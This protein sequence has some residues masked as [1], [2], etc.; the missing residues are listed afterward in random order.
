VRIWGVCPALVEIVGPGTDLAAVLV[1]RESPGT[2]LHSLSVRG[3]AIGVGVAGASDVLLDRIHIHD[4][5]GRGVDIASASRPTGILRGSLI[6]KASGDGVRVESAVMTIDTSVIRNTRPDSVGLAGSGVTAQN[7]L[8][9]ERAQLLVRGSLVEQNRELGVYVSGAD[10]TVETTVVR[11]TQPN[12]Q[13]ELGHGVHVQAQPEMGAPGSLLLRTSLVEQSH[14]VGLYISGDATVEASVIRDTSPTARE[15]FGRGIHVQSDPTSTP[16]SLV[17]RTSLVERNHEG[18]VSI[19]NGEATIIASVVRDTEPNGGGFFG[20]GVNVQFDP[21][22]DPSA[23][24]KL[25]LQSSLLERNRDAAVAAAGAE[26]MVESSIVR[27]TMHAA[28]GIGRAMNIQ[29]EGTVRA[30]LLA[31]ASLVEHSHDVGVAVFGSEATIESCLLRDTKPDAAGLFG[32]GVMVTSEPASATILATWIE[33]SARAGVSVYASHAA[34]GGS[35]LACHAFDLDYE[36]GGSIEDLHGNRCG[37][38]QPIE[39][40]KAV[41]SGLTAPSPLAP[42]PPTQ[43]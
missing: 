30:S 28:D 37:C 6:E 9:D 36:N 41:S 8:H 17:L 43:D 18:G 38:P 14:R 22:F 31:R 25:A 2:E 35:V 40:C 39:P 15:R 32:D 4:T 1:W 13:G 23:T 27:E 26:V 33:G 20:R 24:A 11:D 19:S 34:L 12:Q 5:A 16:A 10:A 3:N 42:T 7:L 29:A 21:A